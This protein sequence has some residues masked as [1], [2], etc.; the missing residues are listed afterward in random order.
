MASKM[1]IKPDGPFENLQK[2]LNLP[3][4]FVF[5]NRIQFGVV[6]ILAQLGARG[7]WH[8]IHRELGKSDPPST[9]LGEADDEFRRRWME[10]RGLA[11]RDLLLR[12]DNVGAPAAETSQTSMAVAL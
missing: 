12:R 5:V 9:D 11:S 7:N 4:D 8:R 6:S 3:A 2:Q 10:E 1:I